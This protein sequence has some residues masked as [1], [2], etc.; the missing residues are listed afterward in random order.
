M[1]S[2]F[3]VGGPL[4]G[5]FQQKEDGNDPPERLA[6]A[7]L[8]AHA[9]LVTEWEPGQGLGPRAMETREY[10]YHRYDL[11]TR[12]RAAVAYLWDGLL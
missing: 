4:H 11:P 8:D 5:L 3:Y 1:I 6:L 9:P 7:A 10:H 12:G 2:V